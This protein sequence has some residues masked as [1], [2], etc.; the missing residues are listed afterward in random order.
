M[1]AAGA[2]STDSRPESVKQVS[3]YDPQAFIAIDDSDHDVD[4]IAMEEEQ[5][6]LA[7]EPGFVPIHSMTSTAVKRPNGHAKRSQKHKSTAAVT[8]THGRPQRSEQTVRGADGKVAGGI[9]N[10]SPLPLPATPAKP[11]DRLKISA[12]SGNVHI[13]KRSPPQ[14]QLLHF[15]LNRLLGSRSLRKRH[16]IRLFGAHVFR[17]TVRLHKLDNLDE[18]LCTPVNE[19]ALMLGSLEAPVQRLASADGDS[20]SDGAVAT[21]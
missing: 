1:S 11:R 21:I 20:T 10:R 13:G 18:L 7:I 17:S 16:L 9:E 5:D 2:A 19:V 14:Q 12:R 8:V 15:K 6:P 4:D 3:F